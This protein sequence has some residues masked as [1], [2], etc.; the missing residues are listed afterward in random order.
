MGPLLAQFHRD[1]VS[2]LRSPVIAILQNTLIKLKCVQI[3]D[4]LLM[5][6]IAILGHSSANKQGL[7]CPLFVYK[8]FDRVENNIALFCLC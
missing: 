8:G 2:T 6:I 4:L 3:R 1:I 7:C 5:C